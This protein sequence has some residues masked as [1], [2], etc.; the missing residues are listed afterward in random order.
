MLSKIIEE[1]GDRFDFVI[2]TGGLGGEFICNTIAELSND[3]KTTTDDLRGNENNRWGYFD[4]TFKNFWLNLAKKSHGQDIEYTIGSIE[5]EFNSLYTRA[6]QEEILSSL[7]DDL[8][9]YNRILIRTHSK[10][11]GIETIFNTS[12]IIYIHPKNVEYFVYAR[13]NLLLKAIG[14]VISSAQ[15]RK[16]ITNSNYY[17]NTNYDVDK[18][19]SILNKE[20]KIY[21]HTVA[22]LV[23]GRSL[24]AKLNALHST[25]E[26]ISTIN[27]IEHFWT[28]PI[29]ARLNDP[30]EVLYAYKKSCQGK[31]KCEGSTERY[32]LSELLNGCNIIQKTFGLDGKEFNKRLVKWHE[33]N[34]KLLK[35]TEKKYNISLITHYGFKL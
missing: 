28:L 30:V 8:K 23:N 12:R 17:N 16:E 2:Y 21:N 10:F 6:E 5:D 29:V 14:I 3:Y 13:A 34:I 22:L 20:S 35:N 19:M 26:D 9:N 1:Y 4:N 11:H 15:A 24:G 18:L 25:L 32:C 33:T 27:T 31:F 7:L